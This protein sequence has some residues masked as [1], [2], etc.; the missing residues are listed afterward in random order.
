MTCVRELRYVLAVM[1]F[2]VSLAEIPRVSFA[3]D[4][5]DAL[6]RLEKIVQQQQIQIEAQA[7]AIEEL[8]KRL[9]ALTRAEE[10]GPS[11]PVVSSAEPAPVVKSGNDKV[12]VKLYG[13]I[14]RAALYAD[15]GNEDN[16]YFVDNVNSTTRVGL[17][18]SSRPLSDSDL[19]LGS[20]FEVEFA[21]NKSTAVSQKDKNNADDKNFKKRH[22]DIF[23]N[24][25]RFGKLSLGHGDTASEGA[26]EIDLSGTGVVSSSDIPDMAGGQFFYDDRTDSLSSTR[27]RDVF[28][29]MD[30][31]G[32]DDRLR[33]DTPRFHGFMASG[34]VISGAGG[35]T[36]LRYDGEIGEFKLAAAAAYSDPSSS[37]DTIDK[38][39]NGSASVLHSSGLNATFA[40]GWQENKESTQ[41]DP[42]FYYGKLGF[43]RQFFPIGITALSLE[44]GRFNDIDE[45]DDEADTLGVMGVQN[46]DDW[47]TEYYLGYRWHKLDRKDSSLDDINALM[48]GLRVK[49]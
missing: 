8:K 27:V 7:R 9:E 6:E 16:W 4:K 47:A 26:S 32:R 30:G 35:D 19:S 44:W 38:T 25:G 29:N 22:F 12:S 15:D 37:S 23:V 45:D 31:L 5:Q 36:A 28:D 13:Q 24:S 43:R 3:V 40:G 14:N 17:L 49:F 2:T 46:I 41:E 34:S 21:A 11:P 42:T 39:V 33:Y 1:V 10:A 18:G 48:T 20:R